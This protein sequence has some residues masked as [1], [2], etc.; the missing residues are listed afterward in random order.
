MYRFKKAISYICWIDKSVSIHYMYRFKD[1]MQ[2]FFSLIGMF[3]YIT[4]IGSS[5]FAAYRGYK[6]IQFQYITCIGS[7]TLLFPPLTK[8]T[9]FQ[10]ITCIGSRMKKF[11]EWTLTQVSI[12]YMYRFKFLLM[13]SVTLIL[14][15]FNTLHVSVQ[16]F[17][18]ISKA[19]LS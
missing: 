19:R 15:S 6:V 14:I 5:G 2:V 13:V 9:M 7:S 18:C 16:G 11:Q 10:Y 17:F 1:V 4:C 8:L 12:H 3:Q